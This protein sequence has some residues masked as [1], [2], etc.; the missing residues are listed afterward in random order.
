MISAGILQK[1][2]QKS[3]EALSQSSEKETS[4]KKI[5][6]KTQKR[7]SPA[8][9]A[10]PLESNNYRKNLELWMFKPSCTVAVERSNSFQRWTFDRMLATS[11]G[12]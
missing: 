5:F 3:L 8:S 10:V 6:P 2:L 12:F 9:R 11:F 4:E 1:N 7:T